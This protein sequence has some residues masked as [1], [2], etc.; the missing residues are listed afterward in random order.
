MSEPGPATVT[1]LLSE[2][3]AGNAAVLDELFPLL[4][5]ELHRLAHRQ[6][7][8]WHG[9]LTLNTTALVHEVY[10]KLVDQGRIRAD[11]RAHLLGVASRAI[12]HILCNY[13]RDRRRLKRGGGAAVLSLDERSMQL[14][15]GDAD[16]DTLAA[17][18]DALAALERAD[19][20]RARVVECRFFGGLTIEETA[21]ALDTSPATVKREWSLARAWLYRELNS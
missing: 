2:L 6:R 4:Y 11:S 1:R 14:Q 8:R 17:L 3:E 12:R 16:V 13:A 19:A 18:A 20:R 7:G 9:D 10:L 5:D 21:L 15:A